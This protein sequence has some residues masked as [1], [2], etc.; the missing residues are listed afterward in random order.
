M[1]I[2]FLAFPPVF[3]AFFLE[4]LYF[5]LLLRTVTYALATHCFVRFLFLLPGSKLCWALVFRA[6]HDGIKTEGAHTL[7]FSGSSHF[8]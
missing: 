4:L 5:S 3:S 6:I 2:A 7:A 1:V 8:S